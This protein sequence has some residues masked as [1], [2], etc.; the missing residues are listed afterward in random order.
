MTD[1]DES[2]LS[3]STKGSCGLCGKVRAVLD[4]EGLSLCKSCNRIRAG[5]TN[6]IKARTEI[7]IC[8]HS[9]T[10]SSL[11][12][13]CCACLDLRPLREGNCYPRYQDGV[14]W[15]D[16]A[17]RN[18]GYCH[19]CRLEGAQS[20]FL[21]P[22]FSVAALSAE[23]GLSPNSAAFVDYID[24][25][26]SVLPLCTD[27]LYPTAPPNSGRNR[28]LYLCGNSLGLQPATCRTHVLTQL[29]KWAAEG[30]EGHF[31][32]PTP[33]LTIDDTVKASMATLVGAN[34]SEVVLMNSLTSNLHFMM[35][36]FFR[37]S[38]QRFKILIE[39]KA[40]PSDVHAVT[41]QLLHH[42]LD[43]NMALL[44]V[45]PRSGEVLLRHEDIET[46]LQR[47]GREIAL[48]LLSG[49][50]YYT[51]QF[52]DVARITAAA[53]EQ[54]C[55]V[56]WDLAHAVGNVPLEL[57][58][59]G[60]DFACWCTYKYL[61]CGP[62]SIGGCF[63]HERHGAGGRMQ[64][65][66]S[67]AGNEPQMRGRVEGEGERYDQEKNSCIPRL[68]GWWGHR[69]DDRFVMDPQFV[70]CAGAD[71]FRVSNPPVL[72]VACAR[73]SLDVFEKVCFSSVS[74]LFSLFSLLFWLGLVW[75]GLV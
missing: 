24:S 65:C 28:A 5:A 73:A 52:F 32:E 36:A 69:L 33:W 1:E 23:L 14:G 2:I 49:V 40:F 54:G 48:V 37:P 18:D 26:D 60:A 41:S 10:T 9:C 70:A 68:A 22:S 6:I 61:N 46:C 47:Q 56:G 8:G 21:S 55:L 4:S 7:K 19:Y 20:Q 71:G 66:G 72:L 3:L 59:W 31:T 57:H 11:K 12:E 16:D 39:K 43:P 67:D 25:S 34:P 30:V 27:F 58:A 38:A 53:H 44:E 13:G 50:Q 29:D 35:A 51:G 62:G 42:G 75:F 64:L 63:V 74:S 15:S 45:A 17:P